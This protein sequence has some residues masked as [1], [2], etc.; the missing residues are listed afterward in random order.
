MVPLSRGCKPIIS[1]KKGQFPSKNF[2][3]TNEGSVTLRRLSR[4]QSENKQQCQW[5]RFRLFQKLDHVI[6]QSFQLFNHEFSNL[7]SRSRLN[8][9]NPASCSTIKQQ[10]LLNW[11]Y[12]R[13]NLLTS[14][15]RYHYQGLF[16]AI[17]M[18][19]LGT[20]ISCF[21][22]LEQVCYKNV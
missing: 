10:P 1:S 5:F 11:N 8:I 12:Y 14:H 22:R 4:K 19:R 17:D 16:R 21:G 15:N 13:F 18:F 2:Q 20:G 6:L 3:K 7:L 9:I